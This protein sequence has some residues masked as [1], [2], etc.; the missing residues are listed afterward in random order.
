MPTVAE[1]EHT[2]QQG[3]DLDPDLERNGGTGK[4][5]VVVVVVEIDRVEQG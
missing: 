1:E 3:L 4:V 2:M 5:D